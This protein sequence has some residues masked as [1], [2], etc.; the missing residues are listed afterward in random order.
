V[1]SK[2]VVT[3]VWTGKLQDQEQEQVLSVL[4]KG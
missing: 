2:G 3:R 4:K 1:D